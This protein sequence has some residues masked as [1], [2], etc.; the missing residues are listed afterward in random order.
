LM[1]LTRTGMRRVGTVPLEITPG[2]VMRVRNAAPAVDGQLVTVSHRHADL[3]H[4]VVT[5]NSDT[6]KLAEKFGLL[7]AQL[8]PVINFDESETLALVRAVSR[9]L[10][11]SPKAPR[12]GCSRLGVAAEK[13]SRATLTPIAGTQMLVVDMQDKVRR[14]AANQLRLTLLRVRCSS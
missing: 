14:A 3:E 8:I 11:R 12:R 6:S 5:L 7:R 4:Y 9:T 2:Q 1:E 10:S 13:L